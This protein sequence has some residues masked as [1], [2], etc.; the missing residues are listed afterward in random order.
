MSDSDLNLDDAIV[1]NP[2]TLLYRAANSKHCNQL[3]KGKAGQKRG[4]ASFLLEP[5]PSKKRC[6]S[7]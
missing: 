6:G 5:E 7:A 2:A 4:D 1:F 3:Q